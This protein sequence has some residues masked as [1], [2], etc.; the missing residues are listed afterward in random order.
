[1][2]MTSHLRRNLLTF[3]AVLVAPLMVAAATLRESPVTAES[4]GTTISDAKNLAARNAA[5]QVIRVEGNSMLPYFGAGAVLV[6]KPISTAK[7]F[8]G[9]VVVYKNRFGETVAHRLVASGAS[10][11]VAQGYNNREVDSTPVTASNLIGVVYATL[12]SDGQPV[13]G[14]TFASA[15]EG[16]SVALAASAK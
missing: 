4:L 1:M 9:M 10:G 13:S 12:H 15:L 6:V 16:T 14:A 7:L 5:L 3:L 8:P 2:Q 11:W